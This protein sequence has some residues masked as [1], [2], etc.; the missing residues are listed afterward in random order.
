MINVNQQKISFTTSEVESI[1]KCI[2]ELEQILQSKTVQLTKEQ[3]RYYG[4]LGKEQENGL[5]KC[6]K[7]FL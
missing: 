7:T 4:K 6:T 1:N 5:K 2:L 3:S